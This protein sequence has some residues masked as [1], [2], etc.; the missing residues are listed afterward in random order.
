[1][2]GDLAGSRFQR[3]HGLRYVDIVTFSHNLVERRLAVLSSQQICFAARA[4]A[5]CKVATANTS[6]WQ[7]PSKAAAGA[8]PAPRCSVCTVQGYKRASEARRPA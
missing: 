3:T 1:M 5:R 7:R 8:I 2:F 6:R 4:P